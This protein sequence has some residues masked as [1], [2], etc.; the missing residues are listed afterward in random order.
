[1]NDI[2]GFMASGGRPYPDEL[3]VELSPALND[4]RAET[5]SPSDPRWYG[6]ITVPYEVS[7]A[8]EEIRRCREDSG[9][10]AIAGCR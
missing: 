1:M 5:G 4:Y 10:S 8:E 3:A 2:V 6:S 7:G 9:H